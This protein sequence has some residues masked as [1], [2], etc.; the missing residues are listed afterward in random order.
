MLVIPDEAKLD[1]FCALE[2]LFSDMK[3]YN[4]KK[5]VA[6]IFSLGSVRIFG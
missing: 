5:C 6:I 2:K 4:L 3:R 1:H